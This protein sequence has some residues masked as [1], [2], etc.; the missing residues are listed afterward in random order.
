MR[1][2]VPSLSGACY[3]EAGHVVAGALAGRRTWDSIV[4]AQTLEANWPISVVVRADESGLVKPGCADGFSIASYRR[5]LIG[6]VAGPL[7]ELVSKR[8]RSPRPRKPRYKRRTGE[9]MLVSRELKMSM[10][11]GGPKSDVAMA[12]TLATEICRRLRLQALGEWDERDDDNLL[13]FVSTDAEY[14]ELKRIEPPRVTRAEIAAEV[15]RAERWAERILRRQWRAVEAVA[16]ALMGSP[17]G[18]VTGW[19]VKA[20]VIKSRS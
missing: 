5:S 13:P 20:L 19:E 18:E 17:T 16:E 8:G 11:L 4:D 12:D 9:C 14:W 2:S 15:V 1:D 6:V 10:W 7:A 3:H